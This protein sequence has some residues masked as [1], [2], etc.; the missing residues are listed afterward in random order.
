MF[1]H[2]LMGHQRRRLA[3]Y[4]KETNMAVQV[5]VL[6]YRATYLANVGNQSVFKIDL[7]NEVNDAFVDRFV[8]GVT[9]VSSAVRTGRY[10]VTVYVGPLF[11]TSLVK[12]AVIESLRGG[13]GAHGA[14]EIAAPQ[15]V[16]VDNKS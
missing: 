10:E 9:G 6:N 11:R 16:E 5:P 14:V 1:N 8:K 2:W 7:V 3:L 12:Q 15:D 4:L 13:F